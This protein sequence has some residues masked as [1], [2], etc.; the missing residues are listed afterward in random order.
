[1]I[2]LSNIPQKCK[3]CGKKY[4][5]RS[6][7][8]KYCGDRK[9]KYGC[10]F[11]VKKE[12]TKLYLRKNK[13]RMKIL[14]DEWR[15]KNSE[16]INKISR[17]KYRAKHPLTQKIIRTTDELRKMARARNKKY[18]YKHHDRLMHRQ[19]ERTQNK[20]KNNIGYRLIVRMRFRLWYALKN[21]KKNYHTLGLIGCTV[22]EL[23]AHIEKQFKHG[24]SWNNYGKNG[25]TID[26]KF[27]LSLI[28]LNNEEE[29]KRVCHYTNLQPLWDYENSLKGNR[30]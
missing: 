11:L 27:P 4:L 21:K 22:G 19:N 10:S 15:K 28:D 3:F 9:I 2:T 6:P 12:E 17:E 29:I 7:R 30:I 23:K 8:Q 14:Y 20:I 13:D 5:Q 1:M 26:H 24:M 16:L 18:Y 25:W